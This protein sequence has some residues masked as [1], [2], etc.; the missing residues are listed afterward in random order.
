MQFKKTQGVVTD[1]LEIDTLGESMYVTLNDDEIS[2][3]VEEADLLWRKI[4]D[5]TVDV[6]VERGSR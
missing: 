3:T 5:W 4:R 2:L 6:F 1:T